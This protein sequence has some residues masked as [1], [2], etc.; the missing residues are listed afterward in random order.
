MKKN[1]YILL[2]IIAV[3]LSACMEEP[4]FRALVA[5]N[6]RAVNISFNSAT[7]QCDVS[8]V[9]DGE[10][11]T[12]GAVFFVI[13]KSREDIVEGKNDAGTNTI[14]AFE[15]D[16][17]NKTPKTGTY[18]TVVYGLK[19]TTIYYYA[20]CVG[21]RQ[22]QISDIC[23]FETAPMP[24][25]E[26]ALTYG[27]FSVSNQKKVYFSQG[28]LKYYHSANPAAC[29]WRFHDNQ[30]DR[31][32]ETDNANIGRTDQW[33]DLFGYGT[34]GYKISPVEASTN[35]V[36]YC[37]HNLYYSTMSNYEYGFYDWG[38]YNA[39]ANGGNKP[40]MWR[41]LTLA[42][43]QFLRGERAGARDKYSAG[44]VNGVPGDIFLPDD[45]TLP[46]MCSF[47]ARATDYTTNVYTDSQWKWMEK[48]GAIFLPACGR[49]NGHSTSARDIVGYYWTS[50][51]WNSSGWTNAADEAY[52][53]LFTKYNNCYPELSSTTGF[54][55]NGNSVRL[56][57]DRDY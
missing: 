23:S 49:R 48:A 27:Y 33:I 35:K 8:M 10:Y 47:V 44:T 13:S 51:V 36:S 12:K 17:K 1:I 46:G 31:V 50:D 19:P 38:V 29:S 16:S 9:N 20:V 25:P 11:M 40:G 34:S 15:N 4:T 22:N 41:T 37:R 55:H 30:Y 57:M 24:R 6:T 21:S 54:I 52:Q 56:V 39:I 3:T 32:S 5:E 43:W 7:L 14:S 18:T 28:N 42:E 53:L 26:G 2:V 45:W